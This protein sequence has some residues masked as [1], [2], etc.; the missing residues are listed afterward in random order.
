MVLRMELFPVPLAPMMMRLCFVNNSNDK[1]L[2]NNFTPSGV[3]TVNLSS[4][5]FELV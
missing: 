5:I 4:L 2:A 1:S 3:C